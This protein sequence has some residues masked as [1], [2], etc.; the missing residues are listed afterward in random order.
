MNIAII[1]AGAGIGL[2]A[3]KQAVEKG[4]TVTALSTNTDQLPTHPNLIKIKGSATVS[5]K[6]L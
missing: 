5:E 1:G 6:S 3:V 2:H 4:H